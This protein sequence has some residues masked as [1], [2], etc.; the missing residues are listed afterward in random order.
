MY[1]IQFRIDRRQW[2]F[3]LDRSAVAVEPLAVGA[4]RLNYL[5]ADAILTNTSKTQY[6]VT[7]IEYQ[8]LDFWKR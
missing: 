1:M 8:S 3:K 5:S 2:N 7:V 4:T 6:Y